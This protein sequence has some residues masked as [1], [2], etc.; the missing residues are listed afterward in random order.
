[1]YAQ[2]LL[3]ESSL[4]LSRSFTVVEEKEKLFYDNVSRFR[5]E[6]V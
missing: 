1:M 4:F 2:V 5:N 6:L 3:C